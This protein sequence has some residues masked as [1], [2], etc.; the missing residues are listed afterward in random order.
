MG[1]KIKKYDLNEVKVRY[2]KEMTGS[3]NDN[4]ALFIPQDYIHTGSIAD[5]KESLKA[6]VKDF[7]D[8]LQSTKI[9]E[10]DAAQVSG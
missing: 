10:D 9:E 4:Q 2:T 1:N 5:D 3:V 7:K 6:F 8:M